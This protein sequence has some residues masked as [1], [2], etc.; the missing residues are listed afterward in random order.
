MESV[1]WIQLA[2]EPMT[3]IYG[4]MKLKVLTMV[5]AGTR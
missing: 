5:N 4:H 1:D 2:Q 3:E